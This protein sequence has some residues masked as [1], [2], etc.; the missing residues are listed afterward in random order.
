MNAVKQEVKKVEV[1]KALP[2]LNKVQP[3]AVEPK[4]A[5]MAS[6]EKFALKNPPTAKERISRKVLF[7]EV[8]KR[9][10]HLENKSNDLKMFDAGND[11]INAKIILK[12]QAGFEFEV[13][14]SNVIKKVRDAMETEL[15][16]LLAEAENE[17]L[18]F[19]I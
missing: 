7:D 3:T 14:N 10:E 4:T 9:Y 18:N 6:I 5:I 15:N 12:N 16:I 11:K 1:A 19:E 17:V 8:S 13:S 2:T